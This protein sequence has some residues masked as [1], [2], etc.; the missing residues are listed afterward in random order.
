MSGEGSL[1]SREYLLS[2]IE[3]KLTQPPLEV[4]EY[5]TPDIVNAKTDHCFGSLSALRGDLNKLALTHGFSVKQRYFT[6]A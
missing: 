1:V 5:I 4:P 2:A 3:L 6:K